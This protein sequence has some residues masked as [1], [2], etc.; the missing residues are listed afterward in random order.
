MHT[1]SNINCR[2]TQYVNANTRASMVSLQCGM[3]YGAFVTHRGFCTLG[4]FFFFHDIKIIISDGVVLELSLPL[5]L[6]QE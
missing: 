5:C 3:Y 4:Q 1:L 6:V 2:R